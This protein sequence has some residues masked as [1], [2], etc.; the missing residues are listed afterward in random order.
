LEL[1][2]RTEGLEW[3]AVEGEIVVLDV[4]D[5]VYL[6]TNRAGALLWKAL[7]EGTT[8]DALVAI[9]V[10]AYDVTP[11]VAEAD[12]DRFLGQLSERGMLE[13]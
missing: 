8:H 5:S 3:R 12:V 13:R 1:R 9:I 6:A 4:K 7:S 10:D 11:A 2:L